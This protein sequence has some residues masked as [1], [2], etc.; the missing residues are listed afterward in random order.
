MLSY[1]LELGEKL[2]LG[3]KIFFVSSTILSIFQA[4]F[5]FP[6]PMRV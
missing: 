3:G 2:E 6:S 4:F 5:F 1:S